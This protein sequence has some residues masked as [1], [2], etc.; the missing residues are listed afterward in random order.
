VKYNSSPT[1]TTK[2]LLTAYCILPVAK[3]RTLTR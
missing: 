1:D 2:S 3:R